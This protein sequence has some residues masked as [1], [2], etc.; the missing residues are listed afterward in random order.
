MLNEN[1][2]KQAN[3]TSAHHGGMKTDGCSPADEDP[4][5]TDTTSG[6]ASRNMSM[7]SFKRAG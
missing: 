4:T 5:Q 6:K 1:R 3:L 2:L 7:N